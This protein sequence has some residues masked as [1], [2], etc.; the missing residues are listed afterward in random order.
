MEG[1]TPANL[2][3]QIDGTAAS[4]P[5]RFDVGVLEQHDDAFHVI[6]LI[7]TGQTALN[8]LGVEF[9][10]MV[11]VEMDSIPMTLEE[12]QRLALTVRIQ[13][14]EA[15]PTFMEDLLILSDATNHPEFSIKVSGSVRAYVRDVASPNPEFR[16]ALESIRG[17]AGLVGLAAAVVRDRDIIALEGV[18]FADREAQ[19]PVDPRQTRFRWAS[20]AKSMGAVSALRRED[21]VDLDVPIQT[22]FPEYEVPFLM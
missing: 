6:T 5:H 3:I 15:T 2:D 20:V 14:L 13:T 1:P 12:G 21:D 16:A 10:S 8:L 17:G 19:I 9:G 22:Y 11:E 7:N 18:G 4:N